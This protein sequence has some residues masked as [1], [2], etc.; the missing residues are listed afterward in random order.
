MKIYNFLLFKGK[1]CCEYCCVCSSSGSSR[2]RKR[3]SDEG[4]FRWGCSCSWLHSSRLVLPV[5]SS[6]L[7]NSTSFI[8]ARAFGTGNITHVSDEHTQ[9]QKKRMSY[10]FSWN[11]L[12][13]WNLP[14]R[15]QQISNIIL[16]WGKAFC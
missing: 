10:F 3:H 15:R 2:Q 8:F 16:G 14:G 7:W 13:T 4:S 5:V 12:N 6:V 11:L 9:L 1:G